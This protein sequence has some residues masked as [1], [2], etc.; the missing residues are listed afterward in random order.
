MDVKNKTKAQACN[1]KCDG[2]EFN[3]FSLVLKNLYFNFLA[4]ITRQNAKF[5]HISQEFD[6]EWGTE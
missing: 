2:C 5:H 3:Y 4:I 1:C 6:G